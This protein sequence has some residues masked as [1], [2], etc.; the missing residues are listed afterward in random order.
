M[1]S[2]TLVVLVFMTAVMVAAWLFGL[3]RRNAGWTDVFWSFGSGVALAGAA[4]L[5]ITPHGLP[6]QR[7]WLVAAMAAVWAIRLGGYIAGRVAGHGEDPRYA[8]FRDD[9]GANYPWRMLFVVLPQAPATAVLALSVLAAARAPGLALGLRDF[10]G[11]AILAVAVVGEA[12]SDS[13]M[14]RFRGD[15]ANKGRVCDVGL[16]AWS[17]HPNY[18]FEWLGWLAYPVIALDPSRPGSWLTLAAP[19]AI[20]VLLTRISGVPP[21]EAAMLVSRGDAYRAYQSRVSAFFPLPPKPRG[22]LAE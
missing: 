20:Y 19:V 10:A 3:A 4:L 9:F 17:R 2:L 6:T 8:K 21:L 1:L 18:F 14:K 16:W 12:A 15:P 7:Q 11:L 13:Q 5:P 22:P